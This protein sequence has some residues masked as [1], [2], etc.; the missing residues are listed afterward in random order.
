MRTHR[1][2]LQGVNLASQ[3]VLLCVELFHIS[4]PNTRGPSGAPTVIVRLLVGPSGGTFVLREMAVSARRGPREAMRVPRAGRPRTLGLTSTLT[5]EGSPFC[6]ARGAAADCWSAALRCALVRGPVGAA[7][8]TVR[9]AAILHSESRAR[10]KE[11]N[12]RVLA[13]S[14]VFLVRLTRSRCPGPPALV[15]R[16]KRLSRRCRACDAPLAEPLVVSHLLSTFHLP[17]VPWV[18]QL[19][20][21]MR[22]RALETPRAPRGVTADAREQAEPVTAVT[23]SP[24]AP[25]LLHL[26]VPPP[27]VFPKTTPSYDRCAK[28]RPFSLSLSRTTCLPKNWP[29]SFTYEDCWHERSLNSYTS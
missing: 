18:A 15:L 1:L 13:V 14:V 22:G 25:S 10:Y 5:A 2:G 29:G 16:R 8:G 17:L 7:P 26:L 23:S 11:N 24:R 4:F 27:R 19:P 21:D 28:P 20:L 12:R 6:D 3:L 9:V